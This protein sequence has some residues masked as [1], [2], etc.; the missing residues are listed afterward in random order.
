[1]ATALELRLEAAGTG[2]GIYEAGQLGQ[3]G[4]EGKRHEH[5]LTAVVKPVPVMHK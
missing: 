2:L 1:M 4:N 5:G 3:Q